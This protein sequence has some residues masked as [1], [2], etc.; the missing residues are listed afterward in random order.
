MANLHSAWGEAANSLR[1]S[2]SLLTLLYVIKELSTAKL[3]RSRASLQS[4][5]PSVAATLF[6]VYRERAE[7]WIGFLQNGGDDEGGAL[8]GMDQ[9]LLAMRVV[10]R[11]MI[12]G[13]DFPNR[14]QELR[15]MWDTLTSQFGTMLALVQANSMQPDPRDMIEKHL[16]QISKLHLDMANSHPAAYALLPGS[17]YLTRSYWDLAH[18]FGADFGLRPAMPHGRIGSDGDTDEDDEP[19]LLEKLTLKGLLLFRACHRM[20]FNPASTFKYQH[21]QDKEEKN[22]VRE[23]IKKDLLTEDFARKI[24]KSLVI[25]FFVFTA[26]DLRQWEEEPDE[27][28]KS[29][30]GADDW[31]FSVRTC[32]EKLFLDIIINYKEFL[33]PHLLETI[34]TAAST[35]NRNLSRYVFC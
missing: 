32:A 1:L 6:A 15:D 5:A 35:L 11:L 2:R 25:R 14:H 19:S 34:S 30:E 8:E 31:E 3:Q 29:Q 20:A 7:K 22:F 12:S 9:S 21:A 28:E 10:R 4:A 26:R 23:L 33:I 24:M 13:Y 16:L 27:W 17:M 18:R